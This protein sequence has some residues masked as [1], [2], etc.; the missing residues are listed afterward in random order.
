MKRIVLIIVIALIIVAGLVLYFNLNRKEE[1]SMN[2]NIEETN[3][4]NNVVN[5]IS[6]NTQNTE[7]EFGNEEYREFILDNIYH[8][9]TDGDIHFNLYIPDSYTGNEAYSLYVTL[10]GWQGLYFQGVGVNIKT[11]DFGF[12]AQKY[13]DKMIILAPQLNEDRK[14]VV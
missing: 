3:I 8:S 7:I 12:E 14:S 10:P 4:S 2:E 9:K 5:S 6:N 13:N 11:E 1:K